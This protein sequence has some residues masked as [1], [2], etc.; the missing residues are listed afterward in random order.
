MGLGVLD[1]V[2]GETNVL[3]PIMNIIGIKAKEQHLE[4]K[5]MTSQ[6]IFGL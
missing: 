5:H 2:G 4:P 1:M 3:G 6:G